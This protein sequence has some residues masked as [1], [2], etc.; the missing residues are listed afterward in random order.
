M[1]P[2]LVGVR[3]F[4]DAGTALTRDEI[5]TRAMDVLKLFDK[6]NPEKVN[7]LHFIGILSVWSYRSVFAKSNLKIDLEARTFSPFPDYWIKRW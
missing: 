6:V 3:M 5:Q 1:R 2:A 4:A 7:I